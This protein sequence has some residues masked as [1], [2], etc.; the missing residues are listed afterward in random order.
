VT[1]RIVMTGEQLDRIG[2]VDNP[3]ARHL[4]AILPCYREFTRRTSGLDGIHV[5]DSTTISFL[6]APQHFTSVSHPVRVDTGNSVG[7]GKTWA[8]TRPTDH[9][10]D[11]W[12]GRPPVTIL[13]DVDV[14]SVVAL[15]LGRLGV[16]L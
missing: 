9:A 11:P 5:H 6:L 1:E 16:D 10:D 8:T 12:S 15:E 7:R 13:T 14:D 3:R 2:A 4:H